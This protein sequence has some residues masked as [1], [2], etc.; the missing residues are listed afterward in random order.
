MKFECPW[1]TILTTFFLGF[2]CLSGESLADQPNILWIVVEDASPNLGAYGETAIKTPHLDQLAQQGIQFQNAFV[3]CPVCSPS[4]SAMVTGI[5]QTTL[6]AHQHRSQSSQGKG[7]AGEEFWDSYRLPVDSIPRLFQKA[8]YHTSNSK[9]GKPNGS[10]GK[11]DYNFI[12]ERS[13][14]DGA[15]W[16]SRKAGQPFF[17]QVQLSGGKNRQTRRHADPDQLQLPKYYANH[18]TLRKDWAKYLDSWV[19]V[20]LDVQSILNRLQKEG[21]AD[22][23]AVFFWTDHGVSHLRGKQFLYEEGIHI[24]LIVRLP[25]ENSAGTTR[26]DLVAHVDIAAT[27][28]AL[29]GIDIPDYVQGRDV[30]AEDHQPRDVVFSARDRCDETVDIIRSVRTERFKYIRNFL[31][32]LSHAQPNTYKDSKSI[33]NTMRRLHQEDQLDQLQSRPFVVPRPSEEL[34]DLLHDPLETSNLAGDPEFHATLEALRQTCRDWMIESRDL[35][36]IP[37]PILEE[38][39]RAAGNKYF[40]LKQPQNQDLNSSLWE[41]IEEGE[42]GNQQVLASAL[43]S[44]QPAMRYWGATLAGLYWPESASTL[45]SLLDDSSASVRIAAALALCRLGQIQF[46]ETLAD[47]IDNSNRLVGLYAIRALELSGLNQARRFSSRI[48]QAE[49]NPYEFTRRIARRLNRR[50]E[51]A[52]R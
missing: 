10:F 16:S 25:G 6:G 26:N 33:V 39:G 36:L 29:A 47:E 44:Q 23:T 21:I 45:Q 5:Y 9:N 40:V 49:S 51:E 12:W 34:Y 13:D 15:D 52:S 42:R 20:D 11:T 50:L 30:L 24:P 18:P 38:M 7:R 3:T 37:E 32:H 2:A 19:K 27:S 1:R 41:L 22:E 28:L 4:R 43:Q 17:A 31:P 46:S 35:G 48:E 8:G 14:Y